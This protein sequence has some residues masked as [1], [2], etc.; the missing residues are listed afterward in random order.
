[1]NFFEYLA[2]YSY[3]QGL[4]ILT[5]LIAFVV[6]LRNYGRHRAFRIV[7]YFIGFFLLAVMSDFIFYASPKGD[8][9]AGYFANIC[10]AAYTIVEF[11]A[12]SLII[13]NYITGAGRR[14][15]IKL[16]ALV[17]L[18]GE[19][20]LFFLRFPGNP[21]FLMCLLQGILLVVPCVLYFYELFTTM[22][23]KALKDRPSFWIVTAI[24]YQNVCGVSLMLS[25]EYM[26]RWSEGAYAL[27]CIS[28]C[29]LFVLFMRAYK[30]SPEEWVAV[31]PPRAYKA[32]PEPHLNSPEAAVKP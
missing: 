8:R 26:G 21:I 17:F 28:Y 18:I 15:A 22:N 11:F 27:G 23:T 3:C 30:C 13:L 29:I 5:A 1:M 12:F 2:Q 20:F 7:P 14:L 6:S 10:A 19:I 9:F 32:N 31:S 24:I 16:N 4:L 25:M